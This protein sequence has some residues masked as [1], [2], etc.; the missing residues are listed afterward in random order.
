MDQIKIGRFIADERKNKGYTQKELAGILEISD[1][2]I[3]K[4]ETGKGFPEI[5]LLMP[6][7]QALDL[8]V[9][10]LLSGERLAGTDYRQKAEENIIK[11]VQENEKSKKQAVKALWGAVGNIAFFYV[12]VPIFVIGAIFLFID[13]EI[14][15]PLM[16]N[17]F[18]WLL[19]ALA[20]KMKERYDKKKAARLKA[21]GVSYQGQVVR[22]CPVNWISVGNYISSRV[23]CVYVQDGEERTAMSGIYLLTAFDK[24]EDF[25]PVIYCDRTNGDDYTVELYK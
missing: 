9:N 7:C 23:E 16:I 11:L 18:I 1:K 10:E 19:L 12:F 3:S 21:N 2:T 4:W 25:C 24:K 6:L 20:C 14:S 5:S 8:D 15:Y 13:V 17:S 22:I